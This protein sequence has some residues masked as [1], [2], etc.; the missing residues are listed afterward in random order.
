MAFSTLKVFQKLPEK[1]RDTLGQLYKYCFVGGIAA[2]VDIAF[3]VFLVNQFSMDYRLAVFF[4]FSLGALTNFVM[5]N[6]FVFERKS[7]SVLRAW[8]RH[9]MSTFGGLLVNEV[10]IIFLVEVM[11]FQSLL[12]AKIIATLC[13]FMVNFFFV[14]YYAFNDKV[15]LMGKNYNKTHK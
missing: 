11:Y 6:A 10:V 14:K 9:Y 2:V 12:S 15:G 13:A 7:L 3:F 1:T 8:V 4:S 5:C